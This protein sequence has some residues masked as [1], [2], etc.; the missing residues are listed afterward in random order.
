MKGEK[1]PEKPKICRFLLHGNC[2][3]G[4]GGKKNGGCAFHHP[5]ICKKYLKHGRD[6]A[7]GCPS[8]N[9]CGLLH[10]KDCEV[11][12]RN[13]ICRNKVCQFRHTIDTEPTQSQ[14]D[15]SNQSNSSGGYWIQ[16]QWRKDKP[17]D[18]CQNNQGQGLS[19]A[20][21][22]YYPPSMDST[23]K[24]LSY[25][26]EDISKALQSL[27][28]ELS[29]F[30][31]QELKSQMSSIKQ[32]TGRQFIN[33]QIE[34]LKTELKCPVCLEVANSPIYKCEDDHLVCSGC[35]SKMSRCPVCRI[36]YQRG[37]PKR[38]RGAE[39]SSE[40]LTNLYLELTAIMY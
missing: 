27:R 39:R 38:F 8:K 19:T 4:V 24:K 5:K 16:G 32:N 31:I 30:M 40:K 2:R 11:E 10:Q 23:D 3:H 25:T 14:S 9:L 22:P 15:P 36:S 34:E 20:V 26:M 18:S 33:R 7:H 29:L 6:W 17:R 28:L 1:E 21:C 13:R 12:K 35:R 37:E